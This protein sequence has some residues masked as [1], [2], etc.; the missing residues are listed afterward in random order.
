MPTFNCLFWIC[1]CVCFLRKMQKNKFTFFN[2]KKPFGLS[3]FSLFVNIPF[4]SKCILKFNLKYCRTSQNL[5]FFS[6]FNLF[7]WN[8]KWAIAWAFLVHLTH[9]L[10]F[11]PASCI[12]KIEEDMSFKWVNFRLANHFSNTY[13]YAHLPVCTPFGYFF[14]TEKYSTTIIGFISG[15]TFVVYRFVFLLFFYFFISIFRW[16]GKMLRMK[17]CQRFKK[18]IIGFCFQISSRHKMTHALVAIVQFE[19]IYWSRNS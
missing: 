5:F 3:T 16:I 6:L 8:L 10:F 18:R 14:F 4:S 19:A 17:C 13:D 2:S 15:I 12:F 7:R 9:L 1:V 11:L